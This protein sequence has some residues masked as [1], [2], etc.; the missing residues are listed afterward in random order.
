MSVW[1]FGSLC[2]QK[3]FF[4]GYL[5]LLQRRY[6][7]DGGFKAWTAAGIRTKSEGADSPIEILKEVRNINK[8][9]IPTF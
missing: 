4:A 2:F 3:I 8:I 9:T 5:G 6:R 7:I 1:K